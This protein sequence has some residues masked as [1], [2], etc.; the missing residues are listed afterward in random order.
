MSI[1]SIPVNP[2][3]VLIGGSAKSTSVNMGNTAVFN[4]S[5]EKN[6]NPSGAI[7]IDDRG[8]VRRVFKSFAVSTQLSDSDNASLTFSALTTDKGS[9]TYTVYLLDSDGNRSANSIIIEIT[10]G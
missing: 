10:V 9:R 7:A 4:I 5:V 3:F 1:D 6:S 8:V 2:D